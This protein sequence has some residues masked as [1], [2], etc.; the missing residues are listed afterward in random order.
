M[1]YPAW[2]P[3]MRLDRMSRYRISLFVLVLSLLQPKGGRAENSVSYKIQNYQ[4]DDDRIRV[5]SHYLLGKAAIGSDFVLKAEGLIDSISGATPSGQPA[6]EG[7]DQVPLSELSDRRKAV[8]IDASNQFGPQNV[9]LQFAY[10]TES[11]Y[12]STGYTVRY[13]RD[14]N[15]KNTSLQLGYSYTDDLIRAGYYDEWQPRD[16]HDFFVGITQLLDPRTILK[17]NLSYGDASGFLNDPYKIIQKTTEIL[18]GLSLPLTFPENRPTHRTKAVLYSELTHHLE[19]VNATVEGSYRFFHDNQGVGS[20]TLGLAWY[21]KIGSQFIL[22]PYL[23]WYRQ[24]AADFYYVS[25]DGT[26]IDPAPI[27]TGNAPYYSADYRISYLDG[28]TYGIKGI[29]DLTDW[30]RI[31]LT[32]ERYEM[33]G[34]DGRT[35]ASAYPKATVLTAGV[36]AW[37]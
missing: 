26:P 19:K 29:Y 4:E 16:T 31:D 34:L 23:R 17:V 21:Q 37:F 13:L 30:L 15:Q 6:P 25:L 7:S 14:F 27:P 12:D 35:S 36:S 5:K 3:S 11:D 20:H 10:S 18:P 9:T 22:R 28:L 2:F 8:I 24:T 32:A 33:T 1:L